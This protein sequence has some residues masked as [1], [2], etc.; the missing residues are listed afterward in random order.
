MKEKITAKEVSGVFADTTILYIELEL[1]IKV[2]N[3][4]LAN[5]V[6]V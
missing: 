2:V 3:A 1:R 5:L 6:R 4:E